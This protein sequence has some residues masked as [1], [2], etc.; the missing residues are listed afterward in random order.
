MFGGTHTLHRIKSFID[1]YRI[2]SN[3]TLGKL[4]IIILRLMMI[5][6]PF[7]FA[8]NRFK[9]FE[10]TIINSLKF[11]GWLKSKA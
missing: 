10:F 4:I 7:Y 8:L 11:L 5:V 3:S 9:N 2:G 1:L 6:L